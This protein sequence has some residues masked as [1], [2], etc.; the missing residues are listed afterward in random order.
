[1]RRLRSQLPPRVRRTRPAAAPLRGDQDST[2]TPADRGPG[3]IQPG[4]DTQADLTDPVPV[5]PVMLSL[6]GRRA[7]VVG[8][9]NVAL[10]KT[11]AL[12]EADANVVVIAPSVVADLAD[13]PVAILRRRYRDGD[14]AAAWLAHAATND[15]GVN[16]LVAAEAERRRIWCIRVDDAAASAAWNPAVTRLDDV[17]VAVTANGDPVRS[18]R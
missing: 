10:R 15:P 4:S 12:L 16:A 18:Q 1:M 11:R 5:Y 14:L 3:T 13:L 6:A 2:V 7:V 8:G 17:T 9:G